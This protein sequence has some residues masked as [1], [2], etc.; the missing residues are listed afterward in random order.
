LTFT[1]LV[2]GCSVRAQAPDKAAASAFDK[3]G[4]HCDDAANVIERER[5]RLGTRFEAE[6]L[7]YLGNDIDKHYWIACCLSGCSQTQDRALESLSLL[8]R[9]QALSLLR[10]KKDEHDLYTVVA[11][12]VLSAVQS[13]HLGFHGLA[14][15]HKSQ[16]EA[17]V[18]ANPILKGGYPALSK[19]DW[20]LYDSLP[21]PPV[22]AARVRARASKR[23]RKRY[24]PNKSLDASGG[25][26]AGFGSG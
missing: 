1:I 22:V 12:Q 7:A 26:R 8:I 23:H 11:L 25:S 16:A 3:L 18:S 5:K 2:I 6:L 17:L 13:E 15:T 9:L 21:T 4:R 19:D 20:K 24:T 10:D 14:I